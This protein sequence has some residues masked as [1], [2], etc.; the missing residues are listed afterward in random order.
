MNILV[1][2]LRIMHVVELK[3]H[4]AVLLEELDIRLSKD[5]ETRISDGYRTLGRARYLSASPSSM[6]PHSG[7]GAFI[8][9]ESRL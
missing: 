5:D 4:S 8:L 3:K 1:R 9:S 6:H 7:L 2:P